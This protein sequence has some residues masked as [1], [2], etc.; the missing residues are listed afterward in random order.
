MGRRPDRHLLADLVEMTAA[1]VG[2]RVP[3]RLPG[4]AVLQTIRQRLA[5]RPPTRKLYRVIYEFARCYPHATFIQVGANDGTRWDPLHDQI[6]ARRW[7]GIMVEP[8]PHVF[9]RL[10]ENYA[11]FP[12]V[13]LENAAI[14][15]HDGTQQIYYV[16]EERS[17]GLPDWY[18][19]LGT[20]RKDVLLSHSDRIPDIADRIVSLDVP[21]MTFATLCEKHRVA[22]VDLIQID[23]E[24]YDFEILR[25]I[26][27]DHLR[28][29]LVMFEH[30]HMDTATHDA[31]LAH[32]KG[33]GY[34][35]LSD[36]MDTV[37]VRLDRRTRRERPLRKY[38]DRLKA[39]YVPDT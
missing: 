16:P 18:D 32:M 31:A 39:N 20:L 27:F 28:P 8:L 37:C 23:V 1:K 33:Y 35:A 3:A 9:A 25:L 22:R 21:C 5:D 6:I 2:P 7:S 11:G 4:R 30:Y 13:T 36:G 12:S 19:G 17:E 15:A 29:R 38:W 14:A 34:D 26:D 10:R 24:G